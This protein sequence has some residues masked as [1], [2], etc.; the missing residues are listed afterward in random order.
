[1]AIVAGAA[2]AGLV[3]WA[4]PGG[5]A[6]PSAARSPGPSNGPSAVS[7]THVPPCIYGD[8]PTDHAGYD[9]WR[10]TLLDTAFRLPAGYVP[11]DLV[12]VTEAGF[13]TANLR[14]R[15][16]VVPSL[17]VLRTAAAS[18][19]H[20]ID[21]V[22]AYRSFNDQADLFARRARQ[23]GYSQ[24]LDRTAKAGH[25]E[26]Q[27]GTAV[28]F[29]TLGAA[30]V[31]QS[32]GHEPTGSWMAA[33]AYRFGF[34]LSYPEGQRDRTCYPYEPWH[35]RYVGKSLAAKIHRS[36]LTLREYLWRLNHS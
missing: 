14:V 19:G 8:L 26:H 28:D 36:G 2:V 4:W 31:T 35:F 12:P 34:V 18:A 10:R 23:A 33:N 6:E 32:W 16:V 20:P 17:A 22:A 9:Q 1:M 15:H 11:P 30:D 7:G 5:G 13:A 21:V 27:L 3:T 25:S 29:K 24:T